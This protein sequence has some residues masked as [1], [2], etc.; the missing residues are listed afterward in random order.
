MNTSSASNAINTARP[1]TDGKDPAYTY[2]HGAKSRLSRQDFYAK[3]TAAAPYV[4]ALLIA[5][6]MFLPMSDTGNYIR[7]AIAGGLFLFKIFSGG[8]IPDKLMKIYIMMGVSVL[9]A[10]VSVYLTEGGLQTGILIH[11]VQRLM[12]YMLLLSVVYD[13]ELPFRF[14]YVLCIV[15]LL[16]HLTIQLLQYNGVTAVND[17][18]RE[19]YLDPASSDTHLM[20]AE[21]TGTSF[22]SG[23]IYMNPNVYM[24]IPSTVLGVILQANILKSSVI[25]YIW[26]F[27]CLVSLVLT[28]SRATV[29]IAAAVVLLYLFIDRKSG[30]LKWVIVGGCALLV[31]FNYEILMENFR[32]FHVEDG[33]ESSVEIKLDGLLAYLEY[34]DPA[35]FLT[36]SISSRLYIHIDA[37]WGYIFKY[38]GILGI[39]WYVKLLLL[40]RRNRDTVPLMSVSSLIVIALIAMTA[41]VV[42]C[43]PVFSFFALIAFSRIT[44]KKAKSTDTPLTSGALAESV[45]IIK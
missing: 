30:M 13:Y 45:N 15:T 16:I 40:I 4:G 14:I 21:Q 11:E 22:R 36:G 18:I 3:T 1:A 26:M 29:I 37:E 6:M 35:Y 5:V 32:V 28:G 44:V 24:V 38:Y 27:L 12:F 43:M 34:A 8:S 2:Y 41:S 25:N 31:F 20:L 39:A 42:L 19:Y 17:F 7:L 9:L 10:V 33:I 23:S